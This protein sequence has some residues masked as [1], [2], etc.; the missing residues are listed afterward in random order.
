LDDQSLHIVFIGYEQG[1][2]K[3]WRVYDPVGKQVH[4]THDAMFDEAASWE[5]DT[6]E[7]GQGTFAIDTTASV[8]M[9]PTHTPQMGDRTDGE[10]ALPTT[11]SASTPVAPS[12]ASSATA[13]TKRHARL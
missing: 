1:R 8:A 12:H 3:A 2:S 4:I 13:A 9:V 7:Q 6:V 10:P 5:W 11:S